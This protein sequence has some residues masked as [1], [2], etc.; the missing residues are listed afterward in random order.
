[1][2]NTLKRLARNVLQ[3]FDVG[4]TRYSTLQRLFHE[5][6]VLHYVKAKN[7]NI[8]LI[9]EM[10]DK[11]LRQLLPLIFK[12]NAQLW[13]DLFVLSELGFKR[14]GYFVEFGATNGIDLSN[15]YLLE[16][17]FG[18][19]GILA[20]PAK[21]WHKDLRNNRSAAIETRCVWRDSRSILHFNE[22]SISELSTINS[23]SLSD[24]HQRKREVGKV[25]DVKTISLIDLLVTYNAPKIVDF[26]SIDTEGSEYEILSN[27]DF[28]KYQFRVITCEHNFTPMRG[29]IFSLL[30]ENGYVRKYREL[31]SFDDW[32]IRETALPMTAY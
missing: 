9:L 12:S 19:N 29:K 14:N 13:Q 4:I 26:L 30:T 2:T 28:D 31:S 7:K 21:C 6:R 5:S 27:F 20:E 17:E 22:V 23:F 10:S 24:N 15:S 1:M 11:Q 16:K 3:Q 25:Y 8:D 32:Y 18:W